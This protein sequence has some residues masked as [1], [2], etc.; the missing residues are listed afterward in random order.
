M[1][2]Y[3]VFNRICG[4]IFM[5]KTIAFLGGIAISMIA[6]GCKVK[7]DYGH[8]DIPDVEMIEQIQEGA[9]RLDVKEEYPKY[10]VKN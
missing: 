2:L 5:K 3:P 1:S 4:V 8:V 9:I 6:C 7:N 10:R